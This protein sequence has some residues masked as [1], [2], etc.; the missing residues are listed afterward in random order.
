MCVYNT[1][2]MSRVLSAIGSSDLV[3]KASQETFVFPRFV[4]KDQHN[5]RDGR[6]VTGTD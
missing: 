4:Y 2:D 3:P 1:T 5:P 6:N